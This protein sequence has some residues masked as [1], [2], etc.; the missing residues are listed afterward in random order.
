MIAIA[1]FG[2]GETGVPAIAE[3]SLMPVTP[4]WLPIEDVFDRQLVE[5]LV[6]D[7]RAFVKGL[8]YNLMS[9]ELLATA[10]L[11]DSEAPPPMLFIAPRTLSSSEAAAA[12]KR[13]VA[14]QGSLAWMWCPASEAMPALPR[15]KGRRAAEVAA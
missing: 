7:G 1:T 10:T 2:V 4:Q 8:R 14:P 3:L 9:A 13:L 11:T 5:K 15:A 6:A 12:S